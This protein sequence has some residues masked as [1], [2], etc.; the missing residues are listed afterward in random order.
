VPAV[1]ASAAPAAATPGAAP[2]DGR[3]PFAALVAFTFVLLISPQ[4]LIPAL[5]PLR[6][7][8]L[9]VVIGIA[10]LLWHRWNRGLPLFALPRGVRIAALLAGWALATAPLSLWF[11]GSLQFFANVYVKSL[12][13]FWLLALVV[14][15]QE[16]LRRLA[17]ALSLMA[18]PI[19]LTGL[20]HFDSGT[21]LSRD[22]SRIAG[23]SAPLTANPNDLALMLNLL[24]PLAVALLLAR[25]RP[26]LRAILLAGI[27]LDA[28][29][30][31]VTFSRAGFLTLCATGLVLLW[32]LRGRAE[33]AWAVAL[34]VV[35]LA[36]IPL[37]P[38][39][40]G[41]RLSTI[42]NL[43]ADPTGSA[44]QRRQDTFAAMRYVTEHPIVGAGIGQDILALNRERG[45]RW[46][47]VHNVYLEYAVDLGLPG[48]VLF[49]VLVR[50]AFGAVRSAERGSA[51]DPAL[52]DLHHLAGG[53]RTSLIAFLVAG[54]FHPVSYH[55]YF[56]YIA[57]LALAAEGAWRRIAGARS[58]DPVP[59]G[60]P[61]GPLA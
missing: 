26:L 48:L 29:A 34:L 19:A 33:L 3:V 24:L 20:A 27:A 35:A 23:Y 39:G 7:A 25:P 42:V 2:R 12:V 4:T 52:R 54:F 41:Q 21:V 8:M 28:I 55:F 22:G 37:L 40:Y 18:F 45:P 50:V 31:I 60:M 10:A 9:S 58:A 53:I 11:G 15:T 32:R 46:T 47:Q 49:L 30:I 36:C 5:A 6:I 43:N 51:G 17:V 1:A 13:V 14:N 56:Y 38:E 44:Q 61:G 16:R 57:G 59:S